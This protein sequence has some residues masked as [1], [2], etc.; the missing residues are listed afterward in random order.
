M[1]VIA[2]ANGERPIGLGGV[3]GGEST[4]CDESTVDVFVECAWFDPIRTAQTVRIT[5]INYDAQ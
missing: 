4:G 1:S 3:M 5:V 2:D